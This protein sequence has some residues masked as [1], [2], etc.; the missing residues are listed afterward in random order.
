MG[1]GLPLWNSILLRFELL[2]KTG[3]AADGSVGPPSFR[4]MTRPPAPHRLL[5]YTFAHERDHTQTIYWAVRG[6]GGGS[7]ASAQV[8]TPVGFPAFGQF[9]H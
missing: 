5:C 3:R 9:P 7:V 2:I 6:F 1:T 8:G 4:H